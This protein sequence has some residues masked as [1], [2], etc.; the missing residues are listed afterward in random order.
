MSIAVQE[1]V[2]A[3][4]DGWQWADTPYACDKQVR[5]NLSEHQI[6]TMISDS[7]PASDPPSTY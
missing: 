7:F 1:I 5:E 4:I 6:D 3:F 2:K